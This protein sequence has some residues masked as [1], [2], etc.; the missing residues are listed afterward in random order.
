ML[1]NA[2]LRAGRNDEALARATE[3][4]TR[5]PDDPTAQTT[6]ARTLLAIGQID[7][8]VAQMELVKQRWP[9]APGIAELYLD[10]MMRAGRGD[11]AFQALSQQHAEGTLPPT[12]RVLLAR[13][14]LTRGEDAQAIELLRTALAEEPDLAGAQNDLAYVLASRGENLEEATELAQEA[15]AGRPE[16]AQI[17]DTLGFVYLRRELGEAALVQFDASLELAEPEST[18]WATAQFHRGLALRQL[19][20]H[21]D[22]V[23]AFEQALASGAEFQDAKEAHRLLAD[24]ASGAAAA[25]A[26]GS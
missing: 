6:F 25:P 22:A 7:G 21:G 3:L 12:A 20:R 15:R 5:L 1:L 10:V 18:S 17:A 19:G 26:E 2:D 16:S 8:A 23:T 4:K 9:A 24:L 14:H 11:E 13:L